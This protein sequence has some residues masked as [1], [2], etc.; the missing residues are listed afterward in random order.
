MRARF[1]AYCLA[2]ERFLRDSWAPSRRPAD[3]SLEAGLTWRRLN[4]VDAGLNADSRSGYVEF[5]ATAVSDSRAYLMHEKSRFER[6]LP[7]VGVT[8]GSDGSALAWVYVDGKTL[9]SGLFSELGLGRNDAC[10]CGSGKK[11]KQCCAK[12]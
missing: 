11:T 5:I 9:R 4:V 12:N 1:V 10:P 6:V 8:P 2:D 7:A 3:L